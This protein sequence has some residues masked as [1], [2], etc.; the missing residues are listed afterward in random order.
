MGVLYVNVV[1]ESWSVI[2]LATKWG[3][4]QLIG[5]HLNIDLLVLNT[6]K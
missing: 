1:R 4:N 5:D 3:F 6:L 2:E